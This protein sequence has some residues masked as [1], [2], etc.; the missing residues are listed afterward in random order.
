MQNIGE[1][2][3]VTLSFTSQHV[4]TNP[5]AD[6]CVA[7]S[8]AAA[9]TVVAEFNL[10]HLHWQ[11]RQGCLGWSRSAVPVPPTD[12]GSLRDVKVIQSQSSS[13][14]LTSGRKKKH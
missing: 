5:V 10:T 1:D 13:L 4:W 7:L 6:L 12:E 8:S 14:K 11:W 2:M 3:Y 9:I